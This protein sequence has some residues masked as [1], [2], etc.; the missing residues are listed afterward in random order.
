MAGVNG[1]RVC[2]HR[3]DRK[4]GELR[5]GVRL[6]DCPQLFALDTSSV[7]LELGVGGLGQVEPQCYCAQHIVDRLAAG[8]VAG[9]QF[10]TV[11]VGDLNR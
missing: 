11:G 5:V 3:R 1:A 6:A 2:V 9:D 10:Q 4:V 8:T 7:M